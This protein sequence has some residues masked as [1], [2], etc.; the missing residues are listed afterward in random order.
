[1]LRQLPTLLPV[2]DALP[3]G[4]VLLLPPLIQL[5]LHGLQG[6]PDV[7]L[8]HRRGLRGGHRCWSDRLEDGLLQR[9]CAGDLTLKQSEIALSL[10]G[11]EVD[12]VWGGVRRRCVVLL[13]WLR[14][15][16]R[17]SHLLLLLGRH[18]LARDESLDPSERLDVLCRRP[19][20]FEATSNTPK[21]VCSTSGTLG[22]VPV[23]AEGWTA[24]AEGL[25]GSG[26]SG[27]VDA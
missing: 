16:R 9:R 3:F 15:R 11:I 14:L 17:R 21:A 8:R 26:A 20:P 2:A 7:L 13:G 18:S 23:P 25:A 4:R 5:S 24:E 22:P 27:G 10:P 6:V 12:G 19:Q 1:V